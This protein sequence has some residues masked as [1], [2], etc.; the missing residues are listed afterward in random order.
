[1]ERYIEL[2]LHL[3]GAITPDIAKELATLQKIKLPYN[4]EQQLE[5]ALMVSKDCRSLNEFLECFKLPCSLLQTKEGI[6]RAVYLVQENIKKQG[7]AYAEIRFAP[8]LHMDKGLTMRE[9]VKSALDG[10]KKSDLKCN[11]ILCCMRMDDN[12]KQNLETVR[13]AKEYLINEE[14]NEDFG[15]V[16]LDLAG[17][18]ALYKTEQF[19]DVFKLA[20]ELNVPFTIHAGEADGVE[21]VKK[22]VEF[23]AKRIGHGVR[24]I[25]DLSLMKI[26]SEKRICLEMCPTSNLQTKAIEEI[27]DFPIREFMKAGIPVTINT[28]DMAI[29]GTNIEHELNL[30]KNT[31]NITDDEENEIY[32]NAVRYSFAKNKIKKQ[33]MEVR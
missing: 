4:D 25:E 28:D 23:G 11:L 16:A 15:V 32:A 13:L 12:K 14:S 20:N 10:L 31:F 24:S 21:S 19:E 18:E 29:C 22:A 33:L 17:A 8:Q 27:K 9:V 30:I 2:H 5:K 1:M 3:D 26:L 6:E 7:V